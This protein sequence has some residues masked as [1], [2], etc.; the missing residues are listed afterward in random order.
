MSLCLE[1]YTKEVVEHFRMHNSIPI[2][3]PV[4]KGMTSNVDACPK[5]NDEKKRKC[6]TFPT[7]VSYEI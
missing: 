6:G 1:A 4:E 3:T 2:D 7:L 5:T